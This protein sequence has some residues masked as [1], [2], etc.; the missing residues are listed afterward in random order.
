M[1]TEVLQQIGFQAPADCNQFN[2]KEIEHK[3]RKHYRHVR[4][5]SLKSQCKNDLGLLHC[6]ANG[7]TTVPSN[8][9]SGLGFSGNTAKSL[10][11]L[12]DP[13]VSPSQNIIPL[14]CPVVTICKE[15]VSPVFRSSYSQQADSLEPV[16]YTLFR[17]ES[18][19]KKRMHALDQKN[20]RHVQDSGNE[21]IACTSSSAQDHFNS[22]FSFIQ[23][24]LNSALEASDLVIPSD[25]R[26]PKGALKMRGIGKEENA[27]LHVPAERQ[28]TSGKALWASSYSR[29]CGG[30]ADS[31][32]L[33][34]CERLSLSHANAEFLCST[35]SWNVAS[36]GSSVT[37]GYGSS[38]NV[39]HHSWNSLMRQYEP[40]LQD[41]LLG[42][43]S[44]LKVGVFLLLFL[45]CRVLKKLIP[46]RVTPYWG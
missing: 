14:I 27:N 29:M 20:E 28:R 22:S 36:A 17:G 38:T 2:P 42:N 6:L 30:T 19:V 4:N 11:S 26:E 41:C 31:D 34:E 40:A 35:N 33:Q 16:G 39:S 5:C 15:D 18:G 23:L 7:S 32:Q 37:S 8:V 12:G 21:A 1:S 43:Q 25:C 10:L 45:F 3:G 9:A 24:S 13:G 46:W 44:I